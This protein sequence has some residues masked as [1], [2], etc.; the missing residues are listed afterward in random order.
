[1]SLW[2]SAPSLPVPPVIAIT[3]RVAAGVDIAATNTPAPASTAPGANRIYLSP[4]YLTE[5]VV[6]TSIQYIVGATSNGNVQAGIYTED[7]R[8]L[9]ASAQVVQGAINDVQTLDITDTVLLGGRLYHVALGNASATGT[10]FTANMSTSS[11][12]N[13][14]GGIYRMDLALPL[15]AD[16]SATPRSASSSYAM[17]A[18]TTRAF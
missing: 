11:H 13:R 18:V 1:M 12:G 10:M 9:V 4:F 15:P 14:R 3:N 17:I 7:L 6:A 16:L 8:Q 2:P 5:T